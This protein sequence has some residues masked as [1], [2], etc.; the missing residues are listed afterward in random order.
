MLALRNTRKARVLAFIIAFS[1]ILLYTFSFTPIA[2]AASGSIKTTDIDNEVVNDNV[3]YENKK[4][5]WVTAEGFTSGAALYVQVTEPDGTLLGSSVG[6]AVETIIVDDDGFAHFNLWDITGGYDFSTNGGNVYKAWVSTDELFDNENT[7]TDNFKVKKYS[8]LSIEK[9]VSSGNTSD[10]VEIDVAPGAEVVFTITVTNSGNET[11]SDIVVEDTWPEGLEFI[12]FHPD[13]ANFDDDDE[14]MIWT[15]AEL[16]PGQ[17]AVLHLMGEVSEEALHGEHFENLAEIV[18]GPEDDATVHVHIGGHEEE[19][20]LLLEKSVSSGNLESEVQISVAPG[21]NVVFTISVINN[22]D[23]VASGIMVEDTW[24]AGLTFNEYAPEEADFDVDTMI[25]TI[26]E[27]GPGEE[28]TIELLGTVPGDAAN[29][30]SFE[31]VASIGEDLEDNAIVNIVVT[32]D[33]NG[34]GDDD[35]TPDEPD[36]PEI[37]IIEDLVPEAPIEVVVPDPEPETV[38]VI[39][40]MVPLADVP[41]TG[42]NDSI[43]LL[44]AMMAASLAGLAA[45]TRRRRAAEIK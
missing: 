41:Q 4:D 8:I 9:S 26:D 40:E 3:N 43:A 34:G 30:T 2:F 6:E 10:D 17:S 45:L 31:N 1:M 33:D 25:W 14:E 32:P 21:A 42:I 5:V 29:G 15:I 37:E 19:P 12:G 24:P 38:V 18:G 16:G 20:E 27:L 11:A 23:I 44:A 13:G 22:S 39:E 36:E 7:K 35:D 28:A